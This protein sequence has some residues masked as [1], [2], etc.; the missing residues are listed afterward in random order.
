M[1]FPNYRPPE[2]PQR[3]GKVILFY[4]FLNAVAQGD[5]SQNSYLVLTPQAEFKV[6][7][8]DSKDDILAT[9]VYKSSFPAGS[10]YLGPDAIHDHDALRPI[11]SVFREIWKKHC[12]TKIRNN[13]KIKESKDA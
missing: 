10:N 3:I 5:N 9:A 12:K 2:N 11:F 6:I 8:L 13:R 4:R 1:A 7:P